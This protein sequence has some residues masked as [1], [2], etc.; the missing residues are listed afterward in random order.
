MVHAGWLLD[1]MDVGDLLCWGEG[2]GNQVVARVGRC[3][4][5]LSR[6]LCVTLS[7]DRVEFRLCHTYALAKL[8]KVLVP[9][10]RARHPPLT[11]SLAADAKIH[12]HTNPRHPLLQEDHN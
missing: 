5:W 9:K 3:C 2:V 4:K 10:L 7:K 11:R 1:V 12:L 8:V 6:K